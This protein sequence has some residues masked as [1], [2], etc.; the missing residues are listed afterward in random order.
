MKHRIY[1]LFLFFSSLGIISCLIGCQKNIDEQAEQEARNYT[2]RYCPTPFY[3][4]TRTD[5]LTYDRPTRTYVYHCTLNGA[6]DDI[7]VIKANKE[8]L[9]DALLQSIREST[10][11]KI[12]KD[13]RIS[14]QYILRSEKDTTQILFK[15]TFTEKD[16]R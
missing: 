10:N 9:H 6:M 5:S 4:Y 8:A 16:Y 13:A 14:F 2:K 7:A 1:T 3:N 11:L 15:D 12:Y